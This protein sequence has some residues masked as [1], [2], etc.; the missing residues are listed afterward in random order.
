MRNQLYLN[1]HTKYDTTVPNIGKL[2]KVRGTSLV[3][4]PS[5]KPV[6]VDGK[7]KEHKSFGK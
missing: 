7:S 3:L 1:N 4:E 2:F 5:M 6:K